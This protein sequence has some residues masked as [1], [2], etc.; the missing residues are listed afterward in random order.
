MQKL[1]SGRALA[2]LETLEDP[3]IWVVPAFVAVTA[4]AG[5]YLLGKSTSE[6]RTSGKKVKK[7]FLLVITHEY[8]NIRD[9]D[10]FLSLFEPLAK[11]V[12]QHEPETLGYEVAIS[13]KTPLKILIFERYTS[14]AAL[15][16]VHQNSAP[17]KKFKQALEAANLEF[18]SKTGESYIE[19]D[20][21]CM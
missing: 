2:T 15:T 8:K 13:D 1:R 7:A 21:G 16:D 20:M 10:V 14:K 11:Y 9:R 12:V 5:A 19:C 6:S 17:F 4:A 3:F 18:A